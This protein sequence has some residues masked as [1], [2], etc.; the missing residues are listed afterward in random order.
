MFQ[1]ETTISYGRR[2]PHCVGPCLIS[3]SVHYHG[4]LTNTADVTAQQSGREGMIDES[5]P[6]LFDYPTL[7]NGLKERKSG[8]GQ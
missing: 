8:D 6:L 1:R 3:K 5:H 7:V 2:A 4:G